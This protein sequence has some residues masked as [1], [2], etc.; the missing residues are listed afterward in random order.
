M[1]HKYTIFSYRKYYVTKFKVYNVCK[2]Q[3]NSTCVHFEQLMTFESFV[4]QWEK[5]C[6]MFVELRHFAEWH[7]EKLGWERAKIAS[8]TVLS[9]TPQPVTAVSTEEIFSP[10]PLLQTQQVKARESTVRCSYHN[11]AL[12]P[13]HKY[14]VD[15]GLWHYWGILIAPINRSTSR[16]GTQK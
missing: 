6:T 8:L 11:T 3:K 5:T 1:H 2:Q 16:C 9:Y 10:F 4:T 15:L 14:H 12:A 7:L 13:S